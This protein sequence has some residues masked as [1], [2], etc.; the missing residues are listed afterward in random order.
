MKTF[1][2]HMALAAAAIT[3]AACGGGGDNNAA[4]E[5]TVPASALASPEAFSNWVGAR[6][7]SDSNDPLSMMD[8]LPPTS[9]TAELINVE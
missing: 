5:T 1:Q 4:V 7:S 8:V 2:L 9:E 6:P 3:L